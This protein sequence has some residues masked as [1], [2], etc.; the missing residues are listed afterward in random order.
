MASGFWSSCCTASEGSEAGECASLDMICSAFKA[1][2][3]SDGAVLLGFSTL[4]PALATSVLNQTVTPSYWAPWISIRCG[5]PW[6]ASCSA[7]LIIWAHVVGG[8]GTRSERYHSSW[9]LVLYGTAYSWPFHVAVC[10]IVGSVSFSAAALS[11]PVHG[12]IQPAC[13][14]SAS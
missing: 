13:A 7:S 5:L 14:I 2:A 9:V 6:R 4:P 11:A 1:G 8:V 12:R 10:S 3:P